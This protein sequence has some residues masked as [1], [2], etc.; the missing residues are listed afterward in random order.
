M[1]HRYTWV[2]RQTSSHLPLNERSSFGVR[3]RAGVGYA[4][5]KLPEF[6]PFCKINGF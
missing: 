6:K 4:R 1:S 5:A 3:C 2:H